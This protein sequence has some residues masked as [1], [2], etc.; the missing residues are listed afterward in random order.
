MPTW[1]TDI[2]KFKTLML[3][4]Q[5]CLCFA[6][7]NEVFPKNKVKIQKKKRKKKPWTHPRSV[8]SLVTNSHFLLKKNGGILDILIVETGDT[9]FVNI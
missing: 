3:R 6:S 4:L 5:N 1:E 8:V 2:A 7:V 9:H